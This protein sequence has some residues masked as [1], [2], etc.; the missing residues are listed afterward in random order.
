VT[1]GTRVHVLVGLIADDRGRW[2]VNQRRTGTHM[3]GSWE[4]PGGK[5][6][7]GEA[8]FAALRREL[9]EELGIDVLEATA[10]FELAYDYPDK[11]VRLDIWRVGSYAGEVAAREG[12]LLR[13]VTVEELAGLPLLEADWP[14]LE[15]LKTAANRSRAGSVRP[16]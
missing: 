9:D 6:Q 8:P 11:R 13:W 7:P 10:W 2:L 3:A 1:A 4:F 12:Q 5:S 15:R 14:I 16:D